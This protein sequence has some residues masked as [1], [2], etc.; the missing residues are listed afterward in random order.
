[1]IALQGQEQGR[2]EA[3][4]GAGESLESVL[5]AQFIPYIALIMWGIY[6]LTYFGYLLQQ[7]MVQRTVLRSPF[8]SLAEI[9]GMID[10]LLES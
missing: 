2:R 4:V 6:P 1:M 3:A 10:P 5:R 9:Q 7:L 8:L